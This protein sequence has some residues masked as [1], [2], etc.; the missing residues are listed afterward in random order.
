MSSL[1]RRFLG[2]AITTYDF[3]IPMKKRR[4]EGFT[5]DELA[6]AIE[7]TYSMDEPRNRVAVRILRKYPNITYKGWRS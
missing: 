2:F 6:D 5:A 3:L 4:N 1:E 7:E